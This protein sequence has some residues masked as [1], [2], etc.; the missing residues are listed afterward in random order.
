MAGAAALQ[1]SKWHS[2]IEACIRCAE[3]YEFYATSDLKE[4]DV[5]MMATCAPISR[6]CASVCRTSVSLM[7]MGSRFAKQYC[8][9]CADF[10]EACA[11]ECERHRVRS[12][13]EMRAEIRAWA[14]ECRRMARQKKTDFVYL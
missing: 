2:C 3:A 14:D 11:R 12:L 6:E 1:N 7:S 8:N 9:L 4:Q 10:C 13:P 5:E